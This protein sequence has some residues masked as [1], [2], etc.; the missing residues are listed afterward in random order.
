MRWTLWSGSGLVESWRISSSTPPC[1]RAGGPRTVM[2][3]RLVWICGVFSWQNSSWW[4]LPWRTS[5]MASRWSLILLAAKLPAA[6]RVSTSVSRHICKYN[7]FAK[8]SI[9]MYIDIS[10]IQTTCQKKPTGH[11][12]TAICKFVC[13]PA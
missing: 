1:P 8:T 4:G 6:V 12:A 10:V 11:N 2:T 9:Y 7:S 5:S 13:L 3:T